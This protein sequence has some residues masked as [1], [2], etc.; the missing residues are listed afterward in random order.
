MRR[1]VIGRNCRFLQGPKTD[2]K[3]VQK[4]R[5]A[6]EKQEEVCVVLLN[7]TK[8][9]NT[10]WNKLYIS[11]I[12]AAGGDVVNFVAVQQVIDE[13]VALKILE[14]ERENEQRIK[15]VVNGIPPTGLA[16]S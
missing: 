11:P 7:Y 13:K 6:L 10:F 2:A 15:K 8:T 9:G 1:Q 12:R 14:L 5:V 3:T 4:I 16:L